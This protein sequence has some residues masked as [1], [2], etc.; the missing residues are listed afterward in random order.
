L[1][2]NGHIAL[3]SFLLARHLKQLL[4][5]ELRFRQSRRG[6]ISLAVT[7]GRTMLKI[8]IIRFLR[9]E[10]GSAA[11]EYVIMTCVMGLMLVPVV[12]YLAT[13]LQT[14]FDFIGNLF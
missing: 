13:T 1:H 4:R 5:V 12:A 8:Q 6:E 7:Y 3:T 2:K 9:Q 10:S 11:I 14:R